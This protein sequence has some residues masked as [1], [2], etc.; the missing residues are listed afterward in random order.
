MSEESKTFDKFELATA[1]LLGLGAIA[2]AWSGF[3]AGLWGGK[4]TESYSASSKMATEAAA[5][6]NDMLVEM[7]H[8]QAI[9][10]EA[11]KLI[12][13]GRDSENDVERSR[14]FELASYLYLYQMSDDAYK[15]LGLPEDV[16]KK[17][18]EKPE[19]GK[20][21]EEVVVPEDALLDAFYTD[22]DEAYYDKKFA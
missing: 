13:E 14:D 15:S 16:L 3:Q 12:A 20:E 11:K 19:E 4:M 5:L 17:S 1:I 10:V 18:Q 9:D 21:P 7:A 8:D 6:N 22:L 2:V